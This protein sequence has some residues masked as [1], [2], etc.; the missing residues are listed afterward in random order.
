MYNV[1]SNLVPNITR[2]MGGKKLKAEKKGKKSSAIEVT[3]V[4]EITN[5]EWALISTSQE[6]SRSTILAS[7]G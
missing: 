7:L 4:Y 6:R 5:A 3:P 2:L 1:L